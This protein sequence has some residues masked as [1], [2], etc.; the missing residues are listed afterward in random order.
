MQTTLRPLV[1]EFVGTFFLCFAVIGAIVTETYRPGTFG[2]LGVA[3]AYGVALAVA[4]SATMH[5]SGGHCNPAVTIGLLSVGRIDV[6]K[7]ALYVVS[8]L[9]GA[10]VAALAIK[11]LYPEMAG[12]VA[13][14]GAPKLANDVTA[15]QGIVIEAILTFIL[16]FAV[17]GTA[18]DARGPK[19]GGLG[20][21]LAL[22]VGM[23]AG[24]QMT[25]AALNP[26]RAIGSQLASLDFTGAAIYWIG[27]VLGGVLAM[28]VYERLLMSRNA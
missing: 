20:I 22:F 21:G 24:G 10:L 17:M 23:L 5:V 6:R 11:G 27:P 9:L 28:Q 3:A 15:A 8:Q 25:G 2:L 1:A 26:A 7:A 13:S 14:L 18:V 19:I 12:Q 4:V 16:A